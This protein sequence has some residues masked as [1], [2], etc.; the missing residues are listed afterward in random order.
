V[1]DG[2]L[3]GLIVAWAAFC[4]PYY[5]VCLLITGF[6]LIANTLPLR[7]PMGERRRAG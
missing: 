1:L 7:R 3:A 6:M 5:A 2:A 4:D